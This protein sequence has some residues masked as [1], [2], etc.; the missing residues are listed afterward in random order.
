MIAARTSYLQRE[1]LLTSL[2]LGSTLFSLGFIISQ[3]SYD[4][5]AP[6][7]RVLA[8]TI[9]TGLLVIVGT[10]RMR[11]SLCSVDAIQ[12]RLRSFA[13]SADTMDMVPMLENGPVATGWNRI[14]E[15][16]QAHTQEQSIERRIA[17]AAGDRGAERYARALRSLSD[18][19]AISDRFGRLSYVNPAWTR[20]AG[21]TN[22]ETDIVGQSLVDLFAARGFD[23]W[24]EAGSGILEGTRP[25]RVEL[26]CGQ[27]S[28][29]GVLQLARLPLE[30][31]VQENEGY[32]WTLR[33]VTQNS[34]ANE[35]HEQF[36]ASATHELRTPLTNIKAYSESLI[37]MENIAPA[38][39]KE[40]F[41]VIHSEAER[42]SRLL[43]ELLDIQQLEAGSMTISTATFD[44]QRMLQEIQEHIL[45]L[46]EKKQL[47]LICRVAPDI[48][49]I[50]ADKE[51]IISCLVNLLGNA[52]KYTPEHGEIR[53]FAEQVDTAVSISVEDTGIGIAEEEQTKIFDRFYRC[54]DERVNEIEG[55]GLGLAFAMEVARLHQGEL[56]VE[57][58]LNFG[59]RFTLRLPLSH[60]LS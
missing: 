20:L 28:A 59:S 27:H 17:Q 57:S 32:V 15:K 53:L 31:R 43:N 24:Q 4:A 10:G 34:L 25:L 23:N 19:L 47:K 7:Y 12:S 50:Q 51:K 46:V 9:A 21:S 22:A 60:K 14:I 39:Q 54:Q 33:D 36:L 44:V 11:K 2:I 16:L 58:R 18:G 42:L 56:K 1:V 40:F 35:A 41:N 29:D 26:R 49:S 48:K 45:P 55:N 52:I 38:Q 13:Q 37:D 5:S 8:L 6:S 3:F 30:G